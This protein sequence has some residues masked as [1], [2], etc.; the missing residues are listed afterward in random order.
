VT[1]L[2]DPGAST[3]EERLA[4]IA[5]IL[6]R[7]LSRTRSRKADLREESAQVPHVG[8]DGRGPDADVRV[9]SADA[10]QDPARRERNQL[11]GSAEHEPS[12]DDA[13]DSRE[14]GRVA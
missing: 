4:E 7:G 12:C 13:V 3:P 14:K 5:L 1:H 9:K 2:L 10:P 8:A 6:A 11:A